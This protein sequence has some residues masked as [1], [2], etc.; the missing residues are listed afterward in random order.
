MLV[1]GI[2]TSGLIGS[3]A[4]NQDGECLDSCSLH[5]PGSRHA[6]ALVYELREMLLKQGLAAQNVDAVAVSRGPGSFTGLRVGM[7]CAKTFAYVTRCRFVS[8]DT[9]AA[10]AMNAPLEVNEVWVTEDAQRGELFV[11]K[12]QRASPGSWVAQGQTEIVDA[13][14]WLAARS[15]EETLIGRGLHRCDLSL[16]R[17]RTLHQDQFSLP[18]ASAV[19]QRATEML[20]AP[21]SFEEL[22]F[23]FWR[24]IPVYIRR[25][26]AE[27][28]RDA[29][30]AR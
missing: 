30:Q 11:G 17:A 22:D 23:D 6:Q 7:V 29:P 14:S 12:Y 10:V 19:A 27:E 8:V 18:T 2:E 9:F 5:Q 16:T 1:I 4:L 26:A 3:V 15:A 28:K 24:A 20:L 21:A 25:S 13:E